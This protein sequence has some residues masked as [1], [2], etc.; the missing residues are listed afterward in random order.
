[1]LK[2]QYPDADVSNIELNFYIYGSSDLTF[3]I[4]DFEEK[5]GKLVY[6]K[7]KLP[8]MKKEEKPAEEEKEADKTPENKEEKETKP[9]IEK[10]EIDPEEKKENLEKAQD[11]YESKE[12]AEKAAKK[13]LES[14]FAKDSYD[15]FQGPNGRWYYN[16]IVS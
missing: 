7:G 1:M 6:K 11:G 8:E 13:A 12:E 15:L 9:Q 3:H 2:K 5:D 4:S 10:K 14:D 16:L